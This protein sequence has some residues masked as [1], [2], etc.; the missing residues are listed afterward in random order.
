MVPPVPV[1]PMPETDPP[2]FDEVL[3]TDATA[4]VEMEIEG[5]CLPT[6]HDFWGYRYGTNS[7]GW[8]VGDGDQFGMVSL[9][10]VG[11]YSCSFCLSAT[12]P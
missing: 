3:P 1:E 9:A 4:K 6:L 11:L 8:I 5:P 2:A 12:P 10:T 7:T